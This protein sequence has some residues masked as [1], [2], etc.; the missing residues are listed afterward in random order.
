MLNVKFFSSQPEDQ[1]RRHDCIDYHQNTMEQ[2]RTLDPKECRQALLHL[3]GTDNSQPNALIHSNS[4]IFFDNIQ[5]QRLL[6][7]KHP[8][9][10]ITKL[11]HFSLCCFCSDNKLSTC[12]KR[13]S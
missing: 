12:L 5:K 1:Y 10:R 3:N 13:N 6:E 7:T 8:R 2:P 11:K 9:F 4:F